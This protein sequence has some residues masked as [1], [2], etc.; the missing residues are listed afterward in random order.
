MNTLDSMV[1]SY[2]SNLANHTKPK[3]KFVTVLISHIAKKKK[4]QSV[5]YRLIKMFT[6]EDWCM[7][8]LAEQSTVDSFWS[9]LIAW[10]SLVHIYTKRLLMRTFYMIQRRNCSFSSVSSLPYSF[11]KYLRCTNMSCEISSNSIR[12]TW[13]K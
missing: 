5:Y 1:V 6:M 10:I 4:P 12:N 3:L 11:V 8:R 2:H 13:C 9:K 7:H